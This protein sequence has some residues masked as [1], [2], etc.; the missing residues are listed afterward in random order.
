MFL[1]RE[2]VMPAW[3]ML[4]LEFLTLLSSGMY[5]GGKEEG[6][7]VDCL[8]CAFH[9]ILINVMLVNYDLRDILQHPPP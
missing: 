2:A 8:I 1:E 4:F 3:V 7:T 6:T 5:S 9:T